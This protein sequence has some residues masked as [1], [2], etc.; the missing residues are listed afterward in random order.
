MT[1]QQ[2]LNAHALAA[3]N[4][5]V[6]VPDYRLGIGDAEILTPQDVLLPDKMIPKAIADNLERLKEFD[7]NEI[8]ELIIENAIEVNDLNA[9]TVSLG[10]GGSVA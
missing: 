10:I 5:S 3:L 4:K 2:K 6:D 9:N 8:K 1:Y 7:N